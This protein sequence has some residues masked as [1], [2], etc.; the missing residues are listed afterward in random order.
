MQ[1]GNASNLH[2][3]AGGDKPISTVGVR[4]ISKFAHNN[5]CAKVG[6][7]G[8]A[9]DSAHSILPYYNLANEIRSD[10]M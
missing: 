4:T 2:E 8:W 6:W 3:G 9:L 10:K 7:C 5:A 1:D